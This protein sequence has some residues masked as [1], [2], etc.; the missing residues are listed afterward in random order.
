MI[1]RMHAAMTGSPSSTKRQAGIN[2]DQKEA[3]ARPV[4]RVVQSPSIGALKDV[5]IGGHAQAL[6]LVLVVVHIKYRVRQ[7]PRPPHARH[8]AVPALTSAF[9]PIASEPDDLHAGTGQESRHARDICAISHL[10]LYAA[11]CG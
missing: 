8:R 2:H 4:E 6:G 9:G 1:I 7:P 5:A 10:T 3:A 11:F